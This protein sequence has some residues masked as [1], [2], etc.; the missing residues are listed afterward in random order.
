ML[1]RLP[2]LRLSPVCPSS[3]LLICLYLSGPS[4]GRLVIWDVRATDVPSTTENIDFSYIAPACFSAFCMPYASRRLDRE[5]IYARMFFFR[6]L[7]RPFPP[8]MKKIMNRMLF[9]AF[10]LEVIFFS[11]ALHL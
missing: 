6:P 11:C 1:A 5:A 7:S 9:S 3:N 8:P 2:S 10:F 4:N